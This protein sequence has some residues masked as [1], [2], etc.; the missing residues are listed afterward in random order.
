M[1]GEFESH[2]LI[3]PIGRRPS[4]FSMVAVT[5]A[6][7]AR[8]SSGSMCSWPSEFVTPWPTISSPRL[9]SRSAMSGAA[10]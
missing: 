1:T 5:R 10:S 4:C 7:M 3:Q 6:I 8:S 9:R 2:G